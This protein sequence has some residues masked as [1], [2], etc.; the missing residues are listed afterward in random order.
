LPDASEARTV[1]HADLVRPRSIEG[2]SSIDRFALETKSGY[3]FDL[4]VAW[5]DFDQSGRLVATRNGALYELRPRRDGVSSLLMADLN[6]MQ[7]PGDPSPEVI[8]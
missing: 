5:A 7:P 1:P 3:R 2:F 6:E 8:P 4:D